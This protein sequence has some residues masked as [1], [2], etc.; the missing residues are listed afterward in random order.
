[1]ASVEEVAAARARGDTEGAVS[2][3]LTGF[4][5]LRQVND[6]EGVKGA[7]TEA[8]A[9]VEL[10]DNSVRT[11]AAWIAQQA[12]FYL[13]AHDA[14]KDWN[15]EIAAAE[16]RNAEHISRTHEVAPA[17]PPSARVPLPA[18]EP[19][20]VTRTE[21]QEKDKLSLRMRFAT[22]EFLVPEPATKNCPDCA[23]AVLKDAR[24]CRCCGFRFEAPP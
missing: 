2:L 13:C 10:T 20:V 1:V 14:T 11:R 15:A 18:V 6:L 21:K 8:E 7:L 9:L 17:A 4:L 22:G 12:R 24:V 19:V 23:K 5:D 3:L 16:I